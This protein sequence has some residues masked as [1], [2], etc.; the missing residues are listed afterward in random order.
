VLRRNKASSTSPEISEIAKSVGP[1]DHDDDAVTLHGE[2]SHD[3]R[4]NR[5]EK[6]RTDRIC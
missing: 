3:N 1:R 5:V 4:S 2:F 6:Y